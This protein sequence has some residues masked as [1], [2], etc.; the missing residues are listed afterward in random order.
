MSTNPRGIALALHRTYPKL[1]R[2]DA[3]SLAQEITRVIDTG[4]A[5]KWTFGDVRLT[6]RGGKSALGLILQDLRSD[7]GLTQGAVAKHADWSISKVIRVEN[8][9][10]GISITDIRFLMDLYGLRDAKKRMQLE[11]LARQG[12]RQRKV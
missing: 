6:A 2:D 9:T 8:G 1:S 10:V 11:E 4:M 3:A 12:Y 5:Q 7:A